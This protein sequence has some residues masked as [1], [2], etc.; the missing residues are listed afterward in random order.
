MTPAAAL[1]RILDGLDLIADHCGVPDLRA[2]A[3]SRWS[4]GQHIEHLLKVDDAIH[5][6][7]SSS[8]IGPSGPAPSL[9]ARVIL[10][11]GRIPRGR[12]KAPDFT[13]P[14]GDYVVLRKA[15]EQ[16]SKR[17]GELE[18]VIDDLARD[19]RR[20]AHPSLGGLTRRQWLRFADIH[21]RH[22]HQII[23]DIRA[24]PTPAT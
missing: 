20:V 15:V 9:V 22:H 10:L 2:E 19:P 7:L 1:A 18:P 12:G 8:A 3:V 17:F 21:Q 23:L 16:M 11:T 24:A 4:V 6:N 14:T 5:R 13:V